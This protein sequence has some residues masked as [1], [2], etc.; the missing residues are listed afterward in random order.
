MNKKRLTYIGREPRR[1]LLSSSVGAQRRPN[2]VVIVEN[3]NKRRDLN[4]HIF[5]PS[6]V[7]PLLL[8][9]ASNYTYSMQKYSKNLENSQEIP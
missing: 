1:V 2:E 3:Q 6:S 7:S 4:F 9:A 5:F 8:L